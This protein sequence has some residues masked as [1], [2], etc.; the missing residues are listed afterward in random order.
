M[1]AKKWLDFKDLKALEP[2]WLPSLGTLELCNIIAIML[3]R[4]FYICNI[5]R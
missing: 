5:K 1:E 3:N 2:A 4:G